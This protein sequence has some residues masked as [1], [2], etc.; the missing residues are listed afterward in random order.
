[1]RNNMQAVLLHAGTRRLMNTETR[2]SLA[3]AAGFEAA[4]YVQAQKIRTRI[5]AHFR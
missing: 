5:E 1:M 3:V 4:A 2:V